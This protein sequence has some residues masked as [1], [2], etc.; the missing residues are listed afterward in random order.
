M[1]LRRCL[2]AALCALILTACTATPPRPIAGAPTAE[3]ALDRSERLIAAE[4]YTEAEEAMALVQ[5]ESLSGRDLIRLRLAR[6]ELA[7]ADGQ[8]IFA[9]QD[10]PSP[11]AT[12]DRPLAARAEALRAEVMLRMG[13]PAAAVVALVD[14]GELLDRASERAEN[15][16]RIWRTLMGMPLGASA[17]STFSGAD[18]VTRGWFD[19]AMIARG[20]VPGSR[21]QL[22]AGWRARYP[23]HPA[24]PQ[25]ALR[26][27]AEMASPAFG[28]ARP[29][30]QVAVLLPMTGPF[31][32]VARAV[33]D[34]L[35]AAWYLQPEPRPVIRVYDTGADDAGLA[36]AWQSALDGG[37]EFIIGPLR[38][39]AVAQIAAMGDLPVP[40]LALNYLDDGSSVPFNFYQFGLA[41]EDEARAAAARMLAE[42]QTQVVAMVPETDWG[43]RVLAAFRERLEAGGGQLLEAQYIANGADHSRSIRALLNLDESE[44]R[45]RALRGI[46]GTAL[47]FEP[48]RR[49]DAQAIFL[50]ARPDEAMAVRPQVR[51]HRAGDLPMY[52]VSLA[53]DGHDD[54]GAELRGLRLC[55]MPWMMLDD[56][57]EWARPR[58]E[59]RAALGRSFDARPRLYALGHD[60]MR[61]T[62]R[63]Q[64]G[65]R[66]GDAFPGATGYV[67]L[68]H[69][70]VVRRELG[71]AT[72]VRNGAE[73]LS[74]LREIAPARALGDLMP[75]DPADTSGW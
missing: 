20:A 2:L 42:R 53:W 26:P 19:L 4:R 59:L 57:A 55:D 58:A 12:P 52:A 18:R 13:D 23:D 45:N 61:I 6:A 54:I 66:S 11:H 3:T 29:G 34:G 70:N 41:P 49:S 36:S 74:P 62:Q 60:A 69:A 24:A 31:S 28:I 32:D 51:F 47:E 8:P 64:Q 25:R 1:D 71:C 5:A 30:G 7:L 72:L 22:L 73:P 33:R 75:G 14:R 21:E 48:R 63:L 67:Q 50:A 39:E 38:R 17:Q 68:D 40:V 43:T 37:A 44:A 35:L 65:W 16:D 27:G 9:L 15:D 10:L 56:N 46:I